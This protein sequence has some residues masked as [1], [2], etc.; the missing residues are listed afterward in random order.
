MFNE[1][2]SGYNLTILFGKFIKSKYFVHLDNTM[3]LK[4]RDY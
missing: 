4:W 3:A 2:Y 1:N